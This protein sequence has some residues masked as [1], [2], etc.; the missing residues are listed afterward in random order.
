MF[1]ELP[2]R[3]P[4]RPKR[5]RR[6]TLAPAPNYLE[7]VDGFEVLGRIILDDA[8][9]EGAARPAFCRSFERGVMACVDKI[10]EW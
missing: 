1:D 10:G 3:A 2:T 6:T 4:T 8:I 5:A 9:C 7:L